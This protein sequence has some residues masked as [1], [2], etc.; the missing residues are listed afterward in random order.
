MDPKT[1]GDVDAVSGPTG[2]PWLDSNGWYVRLAQRL[3]GPRTVDA[4]E[5]AKAERAPVETG[6]EFHLAS[7]PV[8]S[9]L[10]LSV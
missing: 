2:A 10:E 7:P 3:A 8:Y 9:A 6:V 1:R 4:A 5:P